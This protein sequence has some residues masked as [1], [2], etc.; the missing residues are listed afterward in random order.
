M[1]ERTR[2]IEREHGQRLAGDVAR[3]AVEYKFSRGF[4]DEVVMTAGSFRK[5]GEDLFRRYVIRALSL[6]PYDDAAVKTLATCP[7]LGLVRELILG[8]RDATPKRSVSLEPLVGSPHLA[9]LEKLSL[10][11]CVTSGATAEKFFAELDAPRLSQITVGAGLFGARPLLGLAQNRRIAASLDTIYTYMLERTRGTYRVEPNADA[12]AD[13]AFDLLAAQPPPLRYIHL[14]AWFAADHRI[15]ALVSA[16]RATLDRFEVRD[17]G[18]RTIAALGTCAALTDASLRLERVDVA[19]VIDLVR[20]LPRLHSLSIHA[21]SW[22]DAQ[23]VAAASELESLPAEHPLRDI[24]VTGQHKTR[25][26]V[27]AP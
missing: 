22:S 6:R 24:D 13:R 16:T 20:R 23:V 19:P 21:T 9:G 12:I 4:V 5:H 8:S 2:Q 7:H 26:A 15:A 18:P 27:R 1:W 14:D 3:H 25:R 11:G 17:V 10:D